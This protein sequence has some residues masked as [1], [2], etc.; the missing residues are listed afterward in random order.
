MKF[1]LILTKVFKF[2]TFVLFT[3]MTLVYFGVLLLLP[4]DIL[5]QV[6][7]VLQ[8]IGLP[9]V[10][11]VATGIVALGYVVHAIW[12]MPALYGLLLDIGKEII[13]FGHAQIH[14]FDALI[15]QPNAGLAPA[16]ESNT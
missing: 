14:R 5:L 7:R 16:Q 15:E 10:I 4:L 2:V 3:F 9:A 12:K 11:S 1:N 13:G 6:V 8:G